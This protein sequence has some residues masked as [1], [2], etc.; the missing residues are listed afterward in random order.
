MWLMPQ[1]YFKN[2]TQLDIFMAQLLLDELPL[3]KYLISLLCM[4]VL[5][6]IK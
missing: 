5:E 4:C 1:T 3:V 6:I 2:A